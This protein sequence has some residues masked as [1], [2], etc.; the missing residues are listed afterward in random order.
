MATAAK[1]FDTAKLAHCRLTT[2]VIATDGTGTP[3]DFTWY[4]TAPT[5]DWMLVKAIIS[6]SSATGVGNPA[7]CLITFFVD[8]ATTPR[9]L[10][11][12]D[13]GD[14]AVGSTTV[15]EYQREETFGPEFIFPTTMNLAALVSVTPTAGNIDIVIFVQAA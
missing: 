8:D 7:D 3:T 10:R 12:I 2:G 11:T 15:G 5:G 9:K 13:L 4:N 14:P 1:Y 6:A